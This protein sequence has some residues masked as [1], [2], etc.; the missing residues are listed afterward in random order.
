MVVKDVIFDNIDLKVSNYET[1]NLPPHFPSYMTDVLIKNIG[2]G[3]A[4]FKKL[5]FKINTF[6]FSLEIEN[7]DY[8]FCTFTYKGDIIRNIF[9][10]LNNKMLSKEECSTFSSKISPMFNTFRKETDL[11]NYLCPEFLLCMDSNNSPYILPFEKFDLDI[12][13]NDI[14]YK[15]LPFKGISV[16]YKYDP[17]I[18]TST[19]LEKYPIVR[20]TDK[21]NSLPTINAKAW[22]K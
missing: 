4:F 15:E 6:N 12:F 20:T 22:L 16:G 1:Y 5:I 21:E 3:L 7:P 11:E 14:S 9:D 13:L 19:T 8:N 10:V 17:M 2:Y 18:C